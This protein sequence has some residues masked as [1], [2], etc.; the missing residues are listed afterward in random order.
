MADN[1]S[2]LIPTADAESLPAPSAATPDAGAKVASAKPGS[3][4]L[5]RTLALIRVG[6]GASAMSLQ[7]W[8]HR[9]GFESWLAGENASLAYALTWVGG[10]FV[11]LLWMYRRGIVLKV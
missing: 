1:S 6:D 8:I 7:A 5:A 4:V 3:G 9:N 10:W 11:V 2:D